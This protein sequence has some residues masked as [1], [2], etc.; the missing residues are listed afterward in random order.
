M[1]DKLKNFYL[2]LKNFDKADWV[3]AIS[4]LIIICSIIVFFFGIL[5]ATWSSGLK[6]TY[7]GFKITI[8]GIVM[9]AI[10]AIGFKLA[11]SYGEY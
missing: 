7:L 8:T 2:M 4:V 9:F 5:Y 3:M 1:K 10:G 6:G 11:E